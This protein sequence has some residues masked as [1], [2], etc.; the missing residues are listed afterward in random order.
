[1]IMHYRLQWLLATLWLAG[2]FASS[3]AF[4][5]LCWLCWQLLGPV[6]HQLPDNRQPPDVPGLLLRELVSACACCGATSK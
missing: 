5:E 3:S 6:I 4:D 1:M 2:A